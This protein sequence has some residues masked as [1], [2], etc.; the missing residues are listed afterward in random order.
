MEG[1]TS[2]PMPPTQVLVLGI[3]AANPTLV[4]RWAE[5]GTLPNIRSLL[6]RGLVGETRSLDGFFIG[7]TW[8]SLYTGVTPA[9]HGIHYLVQLK[10]GTYEFHRPASAAFVKCAPF[11]SHLSRAGRRVAVLDVPLSR[12]DPS[13]NGI[14]VV[15]WAGH[16][17]VYGFH[18]WP[19][20]V[21][22]TIRSHFGSHPLGSCCDAVRH[23][24][25]DYR[26]FIDA[27]VRG[28][29][30]KATLTREFL[31]Q[32]G[33]DFFMQVFSETHCVGHQCWHLH[34]ATRSEERRVGKEC[35]SRWSP[36]H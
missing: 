16:D 4:T 24:P 2:T 32:G 21:A 7:A 6:A 30:T 14:Q 1:L 22:E 25:E 15:E 35:R 28:A 18:T 10:P 17:A 36:Y 27:L 12:I 20:H 8:P 19:S 11:W 29:R 26:A 3:D 5:D 31:Q 34:D 9:R 13:L 33:W 23:S